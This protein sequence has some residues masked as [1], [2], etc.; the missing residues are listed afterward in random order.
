MMKSFKTFCLFFS[1]RYFVDFIEILK[2]YMSV[3]YDVVLD[4]NKGKVKNCFVSKMNVKQQNYGKGI[5]I[6]S[7]GRIVAVYQ[8]PDSVSCIGYACSVILVATDISVG[9]DTQSTEH[10]SYSG[11]NKIAHDVR[12]FRD[13]GMIYGLYQGVS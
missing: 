6:I 8:F 7:L 13:A 10:Y 5:F 12:L 4:L 9:C 2:G 1:G 11:H 3:T